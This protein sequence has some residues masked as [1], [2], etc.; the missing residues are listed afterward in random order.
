MKAVIMAGGEGSRLRPLTC[1]IPKP[2]A[3]IHGK[4]IIEYIFELLCSCGVTDASVTLGY[5]PHIIEN[6]YGS[7]YKKL[8]LNF[9]REDEPLGTAGSVK[10]ASA[11]YDEP[12]IVIS[13]D[14]M[15]NFDFKKIMNYHKASGAKITIVATCKKDPREYG[16]VKVGKENRVLGFIEK[17]SWQQAL[18]NLANTGVYIVNP[19]C[20]EL[21]PKG[22]SYDF[23]RDLFPMMLERDMPIYCYNTDDY[24][25]DVGNID[26]YSECQRDVFDG[27]TKSYSGKVADGIFAAEVLPKGD[28]SVIPPVYI[29]KNV[30]ICE[31]AVIGPYAVIDDNSYIGK[32][33]KIRYSTVLENSSL[34]N[35]SSVTG[36]VVCSGA[37]LKSRASMFE[38]SVAGS[39]C[40][41][42]ENS[43]VNPNVLIWPGKVIG[44]ETV[45]SDNVKIGNSGDRMLTDKG[46]GE[47][48]GSR[49]TAQAC[50]KIGSAIGSTRNGKKCAVASDGTKI[51]KALKSAVVSGILCSG[52]NV[53][54]FGDSFEAQ[55]NFLVNFCDLGAGLFISGGENREIKLCGEGGLSVPRFFERSIESHISKC[56]FHETDENEIK[57][58]CDMASFRLIYRQEL[59]KQAPYGLKSIGITV[60]C[61]NKIIENLMNSVLS[62]LGCNLN[63]EIILSINENGTEISANSGGTEYDYEKLLAV[64]CLNEMR[65]GRDIAV[66]YDAPGFLDALALDCGKKVYRYLSTPADNSD[67]LARRLAAK[68]VFV[69]D[70]LFLAVKLLSVMKERECTLE[71]LIAEL[72]EKYIIRKT[73]HIG[74]SPADIAGLVGEEDISLTNDFEGIKLKREKGK[75]LIIPERSGD[76]VRILAEA[77]TMEAATELCEGIEELFKNI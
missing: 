77:D 25:C 4:P 26:S 1:T 68:Q 57:E 75:L 76:K 20:M 72:P 63:G 30:E 74:F 41:I 59:L 3:R 60:K 19:E 48:N 40:V 6:E 45:V 70:G 24:W 54:D 73:V 47:D 35:K 7:K 71:E 56:E 38:G 2:M 66:P 33:A 42:G 31:G 49:L 9:F 16:V 23:A 51:A 43:S 61:E 37:A 5:M 67:S 18:S 28:Y 52:G 13:G 53:W 10:A 34:G 14:A 15:C 17:P 22:K 32:N 46:F 65:N 8:R 62:S 44:K 50:V 64:C 21:V 11:G 29:G 36:A 55:L 69:R 12:F 27:R 58:L 39:G